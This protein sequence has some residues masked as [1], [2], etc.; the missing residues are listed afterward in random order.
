MKTPRQKFLWFRYLL[1]I[2]KLVS[3]YAICTST[4]KTHIIVQISEYGRGGT[5]VIVIFH[6]LIKYQVNYGKIKSELTAY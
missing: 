6:S 3:N 5:F 2:L 4:T 1:V